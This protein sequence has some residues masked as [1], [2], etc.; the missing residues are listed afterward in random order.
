MR[1]G[2]HD[3]MFLSTLPPWAAVDQEAAFRKI[4]EMFQIK[5]IQGDYTFLR[6]LSA[7][8]VSI[9]Q[10]RA[11]PSVNVYWCCSNSTSPPQNKSA[12]G[13]AAAPAEERACDV[14][15]SKPENVSADLRRRRCC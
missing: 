8:T 1:A 10:G 14:S 5:S 15:D 7:A 9:F 4:N 13:W 3:E 12:M 11:G 6:C 2:K